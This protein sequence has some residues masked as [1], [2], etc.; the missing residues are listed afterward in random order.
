MNTCLEEQFA[1][2]TRAPLKDTCLELKTSLEKELAPQTRAWSKAVLPPIVRGKGNT[3]P[4]HGAL[5][6]YDTQN[7]LGITIRYL[8]PTK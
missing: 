4:A 2:Q 8:P 6:I 5:T 3:R 7:D 1:L